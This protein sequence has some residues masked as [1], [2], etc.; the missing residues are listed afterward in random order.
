MIL[1]NLK[2][3]K[4][5]IFILKTNFGAVGLE[6]NSKYMREILNISFYNKGRQLSISSD[7]I[8]LFITRLTI[9]VNY[10]LL[11]IAV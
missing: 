9:D 2:I 1:S 4:Y 3:N 6:R 7:I 11:I 5:S 10:L 8:H